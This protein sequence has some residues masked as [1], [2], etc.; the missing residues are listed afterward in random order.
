[1]KKKLLIIIHSLKRGGGTER[2]VSNLTIKLSK[3]YNISLLTIYDFK[4]LYPYSG[5]YYSL[6][7]NSGITRKI[8][9]SFKLSTII[10]PFRIYK[11][12]KQISPDFI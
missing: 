2:V 11:L 4:N 10:R 7:E 3:K 9:S 5:D 12:I 6:K 8:I 1:M